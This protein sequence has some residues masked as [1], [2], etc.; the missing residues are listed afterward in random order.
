MIP[1]LYVFLW[2][3]A[4]ENTPLID[5]QLDIDTDSVQKVTTC[6]FARSCYP[7]ISSA[8]LA[9]QPQLYLL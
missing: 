9:K 8:T 6:V 3:I 5:D 2:L 1:S 4:N 7:W